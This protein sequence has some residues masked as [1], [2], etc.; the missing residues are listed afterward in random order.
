[1]EGALPE[2]SLVVDARRPI[3]ACLPK[4]VEMVHWPLFVLGL[5]PNGRFRVAEP[6][7]A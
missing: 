2:Q 6:L 5:W 3:H 4:D 7:Q 1:M